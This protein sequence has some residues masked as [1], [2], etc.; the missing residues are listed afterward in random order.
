MKRFFFINLLMELGVRILECSNGLQC[1]RSASGT[2]ISI[3]TKSL[4]WSQTKIMFNFGRSRVRQ[5]VVSCLK[6][7]VFA[8][9]T[10]M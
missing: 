1:F 4:K 8:L 5:P 2:I 6:Y 9:E 10:K 7:R 3:M